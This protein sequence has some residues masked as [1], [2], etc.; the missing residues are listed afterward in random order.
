[1]LFIQVNN[2]GII[3]FENSFSSF[4]P[5]R[6]PTGNHL[7]APYWADVDTSSVGSGMIFYRQTTNNS[8]LQRVSKEIQD[9]LSVSFFPSHLFIAT[10]D[11]VSHFSSPTDKVKY[12]AT[13]ILL[14]IS[15]S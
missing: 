2:N 14:K 10:W 1:M 8:L 15:T 12:I 7:I 5:S 9:G 11:A 4:N 3:S 6:F 13:Y